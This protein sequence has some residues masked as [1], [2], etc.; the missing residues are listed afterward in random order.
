MSNPKLTKLEQAFEQIKN[1]INF[2]L[3]LKAGKVEIFNT[4][5]HVS[6][7]IPVA[8]LL[9]RYFKE[10]GKSQLKVVFSYKNDNEKIVEFEYKDMSNAK[11]ES[12]TQN[13]R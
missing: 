13:Q 8:R 9:A 12:K 7:G 11:K 4:F 3:N 5:D 2:Q 10:K 6:L 1:Q